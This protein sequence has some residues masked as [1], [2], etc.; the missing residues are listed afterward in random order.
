MHF[1]KAPGSK[2]ARRSCQFVP[3]KSRSAPARTRATK[4]ALR[5]SGGTSGGRT[6]RPATEGVGLAEEVSHVEGQ[7]MEGVWRWWW[8]SNPLALSPTRQLARGDDRIS[9]H[10]LTHL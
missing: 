3:G 1:S 4:R 8:W 5:A 10:G 7:R 6:L 9:C 2:H